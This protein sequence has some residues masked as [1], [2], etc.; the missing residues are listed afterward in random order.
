MALLSNPFK[1]ATVSKFSPFLWARVLRSLFWIG[2]CLLLKSHGVRAIELRAVCSII[3][4]PPAGASSPLGLELG[5]EGA[6]A[7]EVLV[8]FVAK[9]EAWL[10]LRVF[11]YE[12]IVGCMSRDETTLTAPPLLLI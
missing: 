2:V 9:R 7:E 12:L 4:L 1:S 10:T 8:V 11:C 5:A 3:L 6:M